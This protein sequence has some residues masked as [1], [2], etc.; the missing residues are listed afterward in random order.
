LCEMINKFEGSKTDAAEH[1]CF[2][3]VNWAAYN[4][5]EAIG[6]FVEAML[7]YREVAIENAEEE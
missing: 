2:N 3:V 7:S 6:I 1:V 5:Y 4:R